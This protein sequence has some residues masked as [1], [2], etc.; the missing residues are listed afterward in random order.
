MVR[1]ILQQVERLS[2]GK[3]AHD[4]ESRTVVHVN[5]ID[6]VIWIFGNDVAQLPNQTVNVGTEHGLLSLQSPV[7]ECVCKDA[8]LSAMRGIVAINDGLGGVCGLK[9][10]MVELVRLLEALQLTCPSSRD[11]KRLP[12]G[13]WECVAGISRVATDGLELSPGFCIAV[14]EARKGSLDA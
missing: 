5:H 7:R 12:I 3:V 8:S 4:V 14:R 1:R 11:C 2:K 9:G 13:S 6:L 10:R